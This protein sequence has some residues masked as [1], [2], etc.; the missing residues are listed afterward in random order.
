M[1]V[2]ILRRGPVTQFGCC[3]LTAVITMHRRVVSLPLGHATPDF[4][5]LIRSRPWWKRCMGVRCSN[6]LSLTFMYMQ[7]IN[8]W[9][10]YTFYVLG[11]LARTECKV[12][13]INWFIYIF[14]WIH[15]Y[16]TRMEGIFELSIL[17]SL[18]LNHCSKVFGQEKAFD[19]VICKPVTILFLRH[20]INT[21]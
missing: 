20:C 5:C 7:I 19:N 11:L 4:L 12:T 10:T 15:T 14:A 18:N 21:L 6:I 8:I 3:P 1:T 13:L 2:F 9:F 16:P 17:N